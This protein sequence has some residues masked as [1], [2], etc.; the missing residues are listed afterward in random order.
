MEEKKEG[1][2]PEKEIKK[3][4]ILE[5][6]SRTEPGLRSTDWLVGVVKYS[7]A[8]KEVSGPPKLTCRLLPST[9]PIDQSALISQ[10]LSLCVLYRYSIVD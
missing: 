6:P 2:K 1:E 4:K 7:K 5:Q 9:Q 8:R 3:K 10:Q